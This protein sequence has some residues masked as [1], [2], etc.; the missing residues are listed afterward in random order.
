[1][2]ASRHG[3]GGF[4]DIPLLNAVE[5]LQG[6]DGDK[7]DNSLL[8]VADLDLKE[9]HKSACELQDMMPWT[10]SRPVPRSQSTAGWRRAKSHLRN[11]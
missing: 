11:P 10:A 2:A 8:A 6:R 4:K 1:M 7:D 3:F 5:S 9:D